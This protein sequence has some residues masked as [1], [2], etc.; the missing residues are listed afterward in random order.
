MACIITHITLLYLFMHAKSINIDTFNL[1]E[2]G[3]I[4]VFFILIYDHLVLRADQLSRFTHLFSSS[5][6]KP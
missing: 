1:T 6:K 5:S 2:R 4:E 3:I